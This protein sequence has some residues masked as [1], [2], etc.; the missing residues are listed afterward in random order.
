MG[1]CPRVHTHTS[2]A[3]TAIAAPIGSAVS[4][5]ARTPGLRILMAD[6]GRA[7]HAHLEKC[8]RVEDVDPF[9]LRS[10]WVNPNYDSHEV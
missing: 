6:R 5:G 7:N 1:R 2:V 10:G 4:R 3:M 9:C 8:N